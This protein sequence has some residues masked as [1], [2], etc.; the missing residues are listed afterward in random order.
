MS[1]KLDVRGLVCPLPVLRARKAIASVPKGALLEI[2][3]TDP[4]APTDI[5][6]FCQTAGHELVSTTEAGGTT[7]I[8]IRRVS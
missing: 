6:A 2:L 3:V 4:M 7:T 1:H 5:A 8:T